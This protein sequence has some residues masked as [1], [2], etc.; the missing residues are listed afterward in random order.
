MTGRTRIALV[1]PL[2][3]M[4]CAIRGD[5]PG[6]TADAGGGTGTPAR[7]VVPGPVVATGQDRCYGP[8]GPIACPPPG[9]PLHGQDAQHPGHRP[10]YRDL[11]GGVVRDLVTGLDW[12]RAPLGPMSYA[13]AL[14]AARD[15][16]L[17]GHAD[18]RVPGIHELYSLIDF[19]G[20]FRGRPEQSRPYLDTGVFAFRYA[21]RADGRRPIDVQEWSSTPVR[22]P[23][24]G[25]AAN[26]YGVNFADGRVK[27]YPLM[28][29]RSGMTEP[30]RLMVRLVR[31]RPY[32]MPDLQ[33][34]GDG[35]VLD[36]A[37][38]LVWQRTDSATAMDWP[39]ALAFCAGLDLAGGGWRLPDAK[40][41][42]SIT[43]HARTPALAD[44]LTLS[45]PA[46]YGW[47]S[48]TH[49]EGP[50]TAG[51]PASGPPASG[52]PA[53]GP[54]DPG[55]AAA[56]FAQGLA[57]IVAFGPA[58]GS[59]ELPAG[60]GRRQLQDVHGPGAQRSDPKTG[61]PD[62]WPQGFGPQG[63]DVR[64]RNHVRCVRDHAPVRTARPG[65]RA[66][67]GPAAGQG[68]AASGAGRA[69]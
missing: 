67:C 59:P 29:P 45:D 32:G 27:G 50:P 4:A 22:A 24:M 51:P 62:L 65:N 26:Q 25:Q 69:G 61:D 8:A 47:T 10:A 12:A 1:A 66:A 34:R 3:L 19:R 41:L 46:A 20:G 2:L 57:V 21:D 56:F 9:A 17:G 13:A 36:R 5:A 6:P 38:G 14:A 42:F 33:D 55:G 23:L 58:L 16:R 60:S 31:G 44:G 30:N 48:T 49:L 7:S 68:C 43:D 18:W 64:I 37:S 39:A 52:P 11:G 54:P 53:A 63:D 40:E 35:T 15:S 28:D